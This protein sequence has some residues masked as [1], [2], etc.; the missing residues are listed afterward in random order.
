MKSQEDNHLLNIKTKT[1][2]V[3]KFEVEEH[4]THETHLYLSIHPNLQNLMHD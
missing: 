1:K 2:K 3:L 4:T